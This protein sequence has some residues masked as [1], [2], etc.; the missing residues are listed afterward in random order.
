MEGTDH[1]EHILGR[2]LTSLNKNLDISSFICPYYLNKDET[3][4]LQRLSIPISPLPHVRIPHAALKAMENMILVC[5]ANYLPAG[6][7]ISGM[8]PAKFNKIKTLLPLALANTLTLINPVLTARDAIRYPTSLARTLPLDGA[9]YA[10]H[11]NGHFYTPGALL[12]FFSETPAVDLTFT[13]I[14][15]IETLTGH[16]S[17]APSIYEIKYHNDDVLFL[18]AGNATEGYVQPLSAAWLLRTNT[19]HGP[20]FSIGIEM[21]CSYGSHHIFRVARLTGAIDTVRSFDLGNVVRLPD[22]PTGRPL[23]SPWFPK[24][25]FDSCMEYVKAVEKFK[26]ADIPAKMRSFS[27]DP[28]YIAVPLETKAHLLAMLR[29]YHL[30]EVMPSYDDFFLSGLASLYRSF[31]NALHELLPP[32][33][34]TLLGNP[35]HY[36]EA[37]RTLLLQPRYLLILDM[38]SVEAAVEISILLRNDLPPLVADEEPAEPAPGVPEPLPQLPAIAAPMQIPAPNVLPIGVAPADAPFRQLGHADGTTHLENYLYVPCGLPAPIPQANTCA[39]DVFLDAGIDPADLLAAWDRACP[40]FHDSDHNRTMANE[41]LSLL[42]LHVLALALDCGISVIYPHGMPPNAARDVG[43]RRA[44]PG[45]HFTISFTM[46][47]DHFAFQDALR[48]GPGPQGRRNLQGVQALLG[49]AGGSSY[50]SRLFDAARAGFTPFQFTPDRPAARLLMEEIGSGLTFNLRNEKWFQKGRDARENALQFSEMRSVPSLYFAGVAGCGK[51]YGVR[52]KALA[53]GALDSSIMIVSPLKDL[54]DKWATDLG[55]SQKNNFVAQTL[56]RA[57]KRRT[58]C[59]VLDE[60]QKFPDGY[61]SLFVLAVPTIQ[62][63]IYLGDPRQAGAVV[64]NT[65]SRIDP[66]RSVGILRAPDITAYYEDSFRIN[67]VVGYRF[68]IPTVHASSG[69]TVALTTTVDP[70]WP[71]IVPTIKEQELYRASRHQTYTYSSCGGMDFSTPVTIVVSGFVGDHTGA[72]A[73]YT[74]FTRTPHDIHVLMPS[75]SAEIARVLNLCPA[76]SVVLGV[77]PPQSHELLIPV[78]IPPVAYQDWRI[79]PTFPVGGALRS[80]GERTLY[81]PLTKFDGLGP[82]MKSSVLLHVPLPSEP[83]SFFPEDDEDLPDPHAPAAAPRSH[84]LF[85]RE[86]DLSDP[87]SSEYIDEYGEWSSMNHSETLDLQSHAH[88]FPHHSAKFKSMFK[89]SVAKRLIFERTPGENLEEFRTKA[90]LGPVLADA[91]SKR[92]ELPSAISLDP[93]LL[94]KAVDDSNRKRLDRPMT[95]LLNLERDNDPATEFNQAALFPKSQ[96]VTKAAALPM[97]SDDAELAEAVVKPFQTIVSFLESVASIMGPWTRYLDWAL[98]LYTPDTTLHYGGKTP[99]QFRRWVRRHMPHVMETLAN[100]YSQYDQSCRGETLA[101]E[102]LMMRRFSVPEEIIDL[103]FELV[104][105]VQLPLGALGIMRNSGQWCTLLFNTWYNEAVCCLRY[106]IGTLPAC[107]CGDDMLI[108]G[109][110]LENPIWNKIARHFALRFK[111]VISTKGEFC[112]WVLHPIGIFRDPLPMLAKLLFREARGTV[113]DCVLSYLLE[114]EGMFAFGDSLHDVLDDVSYEAYF[115]ILIL[116]RKYRFLLPSPFRDSPVF[117]N[118]GFQS[119]RFVDLDVLPSR[120][121][122]AILALRSVFSSE[123]RV[124]SSRIAL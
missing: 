49:V 97:Y 24:D 33:F 80:I 123:I 4:F 35:V 63:I 92:H 53:L 96:F 34:S 95:K 57:L 20:N 75:S 32:F 29:A 17:S 19:V 107:F 121:R 111:T 91:F 31:T 77:S 25:I 108:L 64:L 98:G 51:S 66:R 106:Q 65:N 38:V 71:V 10:T 69:A 61:D 8:K 94:E 39:L 3:L 22:P 30:L 114:F 56:E 59:L 12:S 67:P 9:H 55:L 54:R 70:R 74:A 26:R 117:T 45:R 7:I 101:F 109:V 72:D 116:L 23:R 122:R 5:L 28:R 73:I 47:P 37:V 89:P 90:F 13:A 43:L 46:N 27:K 21:I 99:G 58:V 2:S 102:I 103:H 113:H 104:T 52:T 40:L 76:L 42:G 120:Q 48:V 78:T 62:Y 81:D 93:I 88:L 68:Q 15:P 85:I 11:D 79:A 124:H 18:P 118:A 112:S 50:G 41:G 14:V 1:Y 16:D 115:Q 82:F 36:A 105:T 44:A 100:D 86:R 87:E 60:A 110:P 84:D 83:R 6:C 119:R